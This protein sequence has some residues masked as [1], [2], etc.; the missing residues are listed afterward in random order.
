MGHSLVGNALVHHLSAVGMMCHPEVRFL[1]ADRKT[2]PDY[3]VL[4]AVGGSFLTDHTIV[5]PLASSR[6]ARPVPS[7]LEQTA[8][9]KRAKYEEEAKKLGAVFVPLV[10]SVFGHLHP[11]AL[12]FMRL[13]MATASEAHVDRWSGGRRSFITALLSAV[14]CAIQKRNGIIVHTALQKIRSRLQRPQAPIVIP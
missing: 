4:D 13:Q 7:V 12:S 8:S 3:M 14:S 1:G 5:N 2:R 9:V 10:C 6:L 11:T